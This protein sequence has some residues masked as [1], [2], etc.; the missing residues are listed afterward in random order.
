MQIVGHCQGR[1]CGAASGASRLQFSTK[2]GL[3]WF[4]KTPCKFFKERTSVHN[5]EECSVTDHREVS[6]KQVARG[7]DPRLCDEFL[8]SQ[9]DKRVRFD[10]HVKQRSS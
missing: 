3:V 10:G 6:A 4:G 5:T 1:L 9:E 7:V 2:E 8:E